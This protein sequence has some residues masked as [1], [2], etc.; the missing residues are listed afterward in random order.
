FVIDRYGA[1]VVFVPMER[2]HM[3]LQQSHAVVS[4]MQHADHARVLRGN[5]TP[6]DIMALLGRCTIAVGMRLH[7]LI[8][9]ALQG[10]PFIA[11]P[12]ASTVTGLIEDLGLK[13][14]PLSHV[15][16]GRLIAY[17]D[18][19]WDHRDLIRGHVGARLPRLQE[20]A[21]LTQ[22]LLWETLAQRARSTAQS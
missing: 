22:A 2:R 12:Y 20:R 6:Q 8:F 11:L 5:Y 19:C 13:M 9:A 16:T 17:L 18:E 15:S 14:P 4:R 1:D 10:V 3:D 21:R 7:F